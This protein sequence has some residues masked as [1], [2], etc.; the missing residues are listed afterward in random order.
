MHESNEE[1]ETRGGNIS[2]ILESGLSYF[3]EYTS[4]SAVLSLQKLKI[5]CLM[6]TA[7][8]LIVVTAFLARATATRPLEV[9]HRY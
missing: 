7:L 5:S 1:I 6:A 4:Y 2:E 8:R 9:K 3:I